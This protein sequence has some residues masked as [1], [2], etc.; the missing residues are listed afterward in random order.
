MREV[1]ARLS[2]AL[3]DLQGYLA[4]ALAPLL[5]ADAVN[6]LLDYPPAV[7]AEQLRIWAFFQFEGRRGTT[8][9]SD[10]LY[11]AIK[12]IQQ[13]EVHHLVAEER[14]GDYL[15]A[16]AGE[17]LAACP[18]EERERL[19]GLLRHLRESVGGAT[20][21]VERLHRPTAAPG[22]EGEGTSAA[23]TPVLSAAAARDLHRFSLALER[24]LAA[25]AAT[26]AASTEG[27]A[28][29]LLVLAAAGA[30]TS[31]DLEARLARLREAG[32]APGDASGLFRSLVGAI[33]DW[34]V[35]RPKDRVAAGGS[36]EAVHQ[37]VRLAGGKEAASERWKEL[38]AAAAEQFNSR[39][40]GRAMALLDLAERMVR[41]D[42]VDARL[43]DIALGHAHEAYE[44]A[45]VLQ[46]AAERRHWPVLRRLVEIF[47]GWSVR[48]L[49]DAL[50]FQPD[51]KK[52]RLL[53]AL[54][55]VWG[56]AARP[57]VIDRLEISVAERSRDPNLWWY[58]RNL[59]FL[60]HRLPREEGA[61]AARE[62]GLAAPFSSLDQH[63]SF[64]REAILLLA[65]L[66]G[67]L[68]VPTLAQR[69]AE[70]EHALDLNPPV[71]PADEIWKLMN[72]L[73]LALARSGSPA[74][75]RVLL[76]H[77]LARRPRD[78]DALSRLR[79]LGRFDLSSDRETVARLLGALR[80][81]APRKLLGFVVAR[82]TEELGHVLRALAGTPSGEVRQ[83]IAELVARHP[84]LEPLHQ[85]AVAA[86][87]TGSGELS[88]V[89]PSEVD[90]L[91]EDSGGAPAQAQASL[92]GD[93]EV[94]GLAGLLQSFQQSEVSGR[95]VLRDPQSHPFAEIALH[96][97]RLA[98][99]RAG[100]LVDAEAFYQLFEVPSRG[101][102]EFVRA[103]APR[104][105]VPGLRDLVGLLLEAMRRYDELQRLRTEIPDTL[106]LKATGS[107]PSAPEEEHD[108]ELVRRLWGRVR[109]GA[110]APDCEEAVAV[111]SYRVRSLLAHWLDEGALAV[112]R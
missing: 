41:D 109:D 76:D 93:L 51:A 18:P 35:A 5:V 92:V 27:A 16:L 100:R 68:G 99:C 86:A 91:V 69:L 110:T 97:G 67:H 31:A 61:D 28:Q 17:L 66:P 1:D 21:L 63:P 39:S 29:Q 62:L 47:P 11:H 25:P 101:T 96:S 75:R 83:A 8:P 64:Q 102:F 36:V 60:M 55:E 13:L 19:A 77:A 90:S 2:E 95:L 15:G 80:E 22:G 12:K 103:E 7:T 87:P 30:H 20:A 37:A 57:E 14:F 58:Q 104:G 24:A 53:I 3:E 89:A 108:G 112:A 82:R 72:H 73:A 34:A 56:V 65:Q 50:V 44:V 105:T 81:L 10:L 54:L 59:V 40:F 33:P 85:E 74:A 88:A 6:T 111:D 23:P 26:G 94:F 9:L 48:D 107:R 78:G 46:A 43:A 106:R 84:E 79:E 38:L 32:F 4:D 71:L 42:E 70:A 49:L 45:A 98:S 52:R